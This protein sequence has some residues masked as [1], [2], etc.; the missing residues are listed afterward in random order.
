M[1]TVSTPRTKIMDDKKPPPQEEPVGDDTD[2]FV[3]EVLH[4]GFSD[5]DD[6]D[7]DDDD[8]SS[9]SHSSP[10]SHSYL[11][12]PSGSS[13]HTHS[14]GDDDQD[15]NNDAG[16]V[17]EDDE[18]LPEQ[19]HLQSHLHPLVQP[20][21]KPVTEIE[22][23]PHQADRLAAAQREEQ[24]VKN[25]RSRNA[26]RSKM[27]TGTKAYMAQY[28]DRSSD[29]CLRLGNMVP[30]FSCETTQGHLTSFHE[31]KMGKHLLRS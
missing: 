15:N 31:W 19:P 21:V 23:H 27:S 8:A 22:E 17:G 13:E 5:C 12:D 7:D 26:G 29:G 14:G 24:R 25:K 4:E 10:S 1:A 30:D 2:S 3:D 16:S 28:P 18:E 20:L 9:D 6:D 11:S